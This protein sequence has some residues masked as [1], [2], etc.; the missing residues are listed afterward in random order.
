MLERWFHLRRSWSARP[1]PTGNGIQLNREDTE[2]IDQLARSV[3]RVRVSRSLL[4]IAWT[5]GPVTGLGLYGGYFIAYGQAP[6]T[7]QLIYFITFTVLSGLLG[8]VAKVVYDSVWGYT[9]ERAQRHV[10]EAV[11]KLGDLILSSRNLLIQTMDG[12]TREREAALQLL[13]RVNLPTS[14]VISATTSITGSKPF[15]RVLAKID[16]YR[17]AGLFSRISD[18]HQQYDHMYEALVSEQDIAPQIMESLKMRYSGDIARLRHGVPRTEHFISRVLAAIEQDNLLLITMQDVESMLVLAFEL[19]NGREIPLL[20]FDYRGRWRLAKALDRMERKRSRYRI[21]QAAASNRIRGLASWLVEVDALGYEDVPEGVGAGVLSERVGAT[22]DQ[23]ADE[24]F[25]YVEKAEN[26]DTRI[27][28]ALRKKAEHMTNALSLYREALES[29][30]RIGEYHA[31]FLQSAEDWNTMLGDFKPDMEELKIGPRG[32]GIHIREKI[33]ALDEDERK[34]VATH[35]ARYMRS[36]HLE[37]HENKNLFERRSIQD[38]PLTFDG[39][40]QLAIEVALA[41]EPYIHL[42]LPEVQ[43]GIGATLASYLGD[44]EPGMSAS[45]KRRLGEAMAHD[46]EEDTGQAAEHLAVA[47]VRHYRVNLSDTACRFLLQT[48]GARQS[49]L[50]ILSQ[51]QADDDGPQQSMLTI[52]PPNLPNPQRRW[53]R[54]LA[55]AR[56]LVEQRDSSG[57]Y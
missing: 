10:D 31:E 47:L 17:R 44:L 41:L 13:M 18:M 43:R 12:E 14:A 34:E 53:Y 54:A 6:T 30:K 27:W 16:S 7:Q 4:G 52:R 37:T 5:A 57:G 28:E 55:R 45:E 40:R 2:R 35:L 32:R 33:I 20:I 49:V 25:G 29:Y 23:L 22:I 46:V 48:Y 39:A 56:R 8:L 11:D 19:I 26:G 42:S 1:R 21:A 24:L 15:G 50:D 38:N 51:Y 3:R 9:S 36:Q